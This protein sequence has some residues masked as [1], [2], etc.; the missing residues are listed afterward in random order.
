MSESEMRS[1]NAIIKWRAKNE[2]KRAILP[3]Y[4]QLNKVRIQFW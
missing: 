2:K 4:L 1:N 3:I